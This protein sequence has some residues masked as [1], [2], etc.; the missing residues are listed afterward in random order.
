MKLIVA[1]LALGAMAGCGHVHAQMTQMTGGYI[2]S[3][4]AD[5]IVISTVP[6][7]GGVPLTY[8]GAPPPSPQPVW[9]PDPSAGHYD[10]VEGYSHYER[11]KDQPKL[12]YD[13]PIAAPYFVGPKPTVDAKGHVLG[14]RPAP[15][16]CVKDGKP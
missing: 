12:P 16:I 8:G 9:V 14:E 1:L 5:S 13:G 3:S 2:C 7:P 15:G 11:S 6:C 10:C 4:G